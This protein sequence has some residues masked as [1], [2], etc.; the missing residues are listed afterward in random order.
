[1]NYSEE[2]WVDLKDERSNLVKL[3]KSD[4]FLFSDG[5]KDSLDITMLLTYALCH[6]H[7]MPSDRVQV[8]M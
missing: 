1:M 3:M 5:E 8:F 4:L 2:V 6:C 7:A